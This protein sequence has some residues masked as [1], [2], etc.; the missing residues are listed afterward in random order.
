MIN[1]AKNLFDRGVA[2][3]WTREVYKVSDVDVRTPRASYKLQDIEGED[4]EGWF[5][6]DQ[7]HKV[8]P[9]IDHLNEVSLVI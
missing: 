2:P 8:L 5:V 4:I 9:P 3:K 1:T 6:R 7:F